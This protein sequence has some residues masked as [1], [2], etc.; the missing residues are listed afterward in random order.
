MGG[1]MRKDDGTP[2][3]AINRPVKSGD[4]STGLGSVK[5]QHGYFLERG[6]IE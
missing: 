3:G 1:G 6:A 2:G 4:K 5:K